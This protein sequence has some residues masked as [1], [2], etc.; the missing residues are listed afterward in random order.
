MG[1]FWQLLILLEKIITDEF[2]GIFPRLFQ[3]LYTP[4][5]RNMLP[6][7]NTIEPAHD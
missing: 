1:T 4:L 2:I 6:K 5:I 7:I 3:T